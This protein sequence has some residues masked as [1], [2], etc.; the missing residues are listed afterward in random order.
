MELNNHRCR[1]IIWQN[2]T[3]FHDKNSTKVNI[4]GMNLSSKMTIYEKPTDDIILTGRKLKTYS[5]SS[6]TRHEGPLLHFYST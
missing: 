3:F 5:L 6:D 4:E 2:S 1:E